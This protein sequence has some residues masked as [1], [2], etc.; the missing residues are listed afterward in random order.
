MGLD[1]AVMIADR[2][3]LTRVPS[4]ERVARLRD[5][6][7][8]D[9]TGLW[10][11]EALAGGTGWIWPRGPNGALFA[12][13]EFRLT[14]GSFKAHC[15]AGHRCERVR[16]YVSPFLRS[17][18]DALLCGLFRDGPGCEAE[19]ID[20]GFF[21]EGGYGVLLAR[22]PES[23]RELAMAW[24]RAVPHLDRMRGPSA[25]TPRSPMAGSRTSTRS[26]TY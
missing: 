25:S 20:T 17:Q 1:I 21:G 10:D 9:D 23:V 2:S 22:S 11:H 5:A 3:W 13:Y 14:S 4:R 24:E 6:W 12:V 26:W 7:H 18:L 16:G 19:H 8:A 15:W